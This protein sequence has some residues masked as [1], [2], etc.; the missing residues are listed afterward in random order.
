MNN[1][2]PLCPG[3]LLAGM[4]VLAAPAAHASVQV[5]GG[6]D[7]LNPAYEA[8]LEGWLGQGS[9]TLTNVFDHAPGDGKTSYDFHAAADGQGP[10]ITLIRVLSGWGYHYDSSTYTENYSAYSI[11]PQI[12][13]GYNPQSWSSSADYHYTLTDADRTAFLFNLTGT[14]KQGQKLSSGLADYQTYNHSAY[15]PTFGGGHDLHVDYSL[16]SGYALSFS[17]GNGLYSSTNPDDIL[18]EIGA[19]DP[20]DYSYALNLY[21]G[22]IEVFTISPFSANVPEPTPIVVW[23]L[24]GCTGVAMIAWKRRAMALLG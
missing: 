21:Y 8:Q 7:L 3:F 9:I 23:S 10:T 14:V 13:G 11:G 17:Y 6:S 20:G 2:L 19:N 15:G 5:V 24:L 18:I 16:S 1:N 4:A 12:I 22:D